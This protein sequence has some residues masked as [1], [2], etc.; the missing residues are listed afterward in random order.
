VS[1]NLGVTLP[2]YMGYVDDI[3]TAVLSDKIDNILNAFNSFHPIK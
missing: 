2:F 1:D 3:A